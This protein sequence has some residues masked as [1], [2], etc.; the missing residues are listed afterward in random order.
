VAV[1]DNY[2]PGNMFRLGA[3]IRPSVEATARAD[4]P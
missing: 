3:N 2:D 1:K 4:R